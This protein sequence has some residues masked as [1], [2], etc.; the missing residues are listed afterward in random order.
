MEKKRK[1][2]CTRW[3]LI[4]RPPE[5]CSAGVLS[6][7]LVILHLIFLGFKPGPLGPYAVTL[8]L[9]CGKVKRPS[10]HPQHL[11]ILG[12][13]PDFFSKLLFHATELSSRWPK[14]SFS[15][16]DNQIFMFQLFLNF[17]WK[18]YWR[19]SWQEKAF[20]SGSTIVQLIFSSK[21]NFLILERISKVQNP[22]LN[23]WKL[24]KKR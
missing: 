14:L 4:P 6:T 22:T 13:N 15:V 8:P 7:A 5:F 21:K 18:T 2:S 16:A 10:H 1:K 9:T 3:D 23:P 24:G 12:S 11:T 20:Y 17:S 19:S